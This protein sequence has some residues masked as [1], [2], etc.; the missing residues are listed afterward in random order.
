M[1]AETENIDAEVNESATDETPTDEVTTDTE[2]AD[3]GDEPLGDG[4]KKALEYE[5]AARKAAQAELKALKA[6]KAP[7]TTDERVAALEAEML[8]NK[9]EAARERVA[10]KHNL[11]DEQVEALAELTDIATMEKFAAMFA[12]APS[13]PAGSTTQERHPNFGGGNVSLSDNGVARAK[14]FLKKD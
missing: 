4:G 12:K 14:R 3:K 5:R 8:A 9:A 6:A 11:T 7:V 2:T 1:D 10:R 13:A